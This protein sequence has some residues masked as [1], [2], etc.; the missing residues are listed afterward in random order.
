MY[1]IHSPSSTITLISWL[2]QSSSKALQSGSI[3]LFDPWWLVYSIS[4]NKSRNSV[5]VP[6]TQPQLHHHVNIM[7]RSKLKQGSSVRQYNTGWPKMIGKLQ[8]FTQVKNFG[9]TTPAPQSRWL[10]VKVKA[11][12]RY[13]SPANPEWLVYYISPQSG[14]YCMTLKNLHFFIP[15]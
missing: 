12:A 8:I 15:W 11:E 4:V 9:H 2:G 6:Y 3:I 14:E 5:H 1:L 7:V 13:F 10:C